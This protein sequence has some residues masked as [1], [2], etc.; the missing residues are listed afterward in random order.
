MTTDPRSRRHD[1]YHAFL[2]RVSRA[3]PAR[4]WEAVAKD[5]VTGEEYTFPDPN[6][7]LQFLSDRLPHTGGGRVTPHS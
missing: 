4:P 3:D 1:D 2:V 5:V 6:A 7:L